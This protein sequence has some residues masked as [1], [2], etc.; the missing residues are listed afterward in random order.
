MFTPIRI[1][2]A[3][4]AVGRTNERF[5]LDFK[6]EGTADAFE[7]AKDVASF[8]NGDGGTILIGA[9]GSG[10]FL[11]SYQPLDTKSA[12]DAQRAIDTAVRDRCAPVPLFDITAIEKDAGFVLAVNVWPFPG[13]VVG[14][15]LK[16]GEAKA[17]A[18]QKEVQGVY[19][20]PRRVGAHTTFIR[21]EQIPMFMD[22]RVR[23][24][25]I[26]LQQVI[27]QTI[28]MID[29]RQGPAT[30]EGSGMNLDAVR[31]DNVDQATNTF[32]VTMERGLPQPVQVGL[33]I[34]AIESIWREG[35]VWRIGVRGRLRR[36]QWMPDLNEPA[37][38]R[39][40]YHFDMRG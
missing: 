18:S 38:E 29:T 25:A 11:A 21:P 39:I 9:K 32:C 10:E 36:M 40:A 22:A 34:D 35:E 8:A 1:T 23:R 3:L 30:G 37:L 7:N 20:F 17:G 26:M 13:Q 28:V 19:V 27:G 31:I 4:P 33:P 6:A 15:E 16:K 24:H 14:V 12:S 2:A 5:Y